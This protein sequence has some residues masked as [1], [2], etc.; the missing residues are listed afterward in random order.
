MGR[1]KIKGDVHD[2]ARYSLLPTPC[3]TTAAG[4]YGS[5]AT[6]STGCRAPQGLNWPWYRLDPST[7]P[8]C[9]GGTA[10]RSRNA[11]RIIV[12]AGLPAEPSTAAPDCAT[13]VRS[14]GES[15]SRFSAPRQPALAL[16]IRQLVY[17]AQLIH[18]P[19]LFALGKTAKLG[20]LRNNCCCCG[21]GVLRLV[22][23]HAPRCPG[24]A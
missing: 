5:R 24:G 3:L 4:A 2:G 14:S 10:F 12:L 8:R 16:C 17:P 9:S 13:R 7:I 19:L 20:S 18:D 22:L 21:N 11:L 6:C 1:G 15:L 23:S